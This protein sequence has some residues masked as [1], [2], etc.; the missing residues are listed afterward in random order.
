MIRGEKHQLFVIGVLEHSQKLYP[1]H[2][3]KYIEQTQ[4]LIILREQILIPQNDNQVSK[5]QRDK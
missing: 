1:M 5:D 4:P 2:N 3:R